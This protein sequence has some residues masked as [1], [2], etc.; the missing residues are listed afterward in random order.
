MEIKATTK[1][2]LSDEIFSIEE[3]YKYPVC[4]KC[5][6]TGKLELVVG[7]QVTCIQ[8]HGSKMEEEENLV[9]MYY[10]PSKKLTVDAITVEVDKNELVIVYWCEDEEGFKCHQGFYEKDC[11]RTLEEAEQECF[12]R[13]EKPVGEE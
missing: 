5:N 3:N 11:F 1:Y 9:K 8:C 12:H 6:G 10:K 13:G 2:N 4:K 7:G